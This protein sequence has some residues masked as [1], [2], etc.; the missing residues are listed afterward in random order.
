M[1]L[2]SARSD[3]FRRK[4]GEEDPLGAPSVDAEGYTNNLREL[5]EVLSTA[6]GLRMY[7]SAYLQNIRY[8]V[9]RYTEL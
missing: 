1:L 9:E 8:K 2:R 6:N 5:V 4:C 3:A 7:E